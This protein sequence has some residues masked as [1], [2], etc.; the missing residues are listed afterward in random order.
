MSSPFLTLL[1]RFCFVLLCFRFL[2][3]GLDIFLVN[4][5]SFVLFLP[6]CTIL[7]CI[8][9]LSKDFVFYS[10]VTKRDI[11]LVYVDAFSFVFG[12]LFSLLL[13]IY[14]LKLST[15]SRSILL[16]VPSRRF[17]SIH[18]PKPHCTRL[19]NCSLSYEGP[20]AKPITPN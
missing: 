8:M 18:D 14:C 9:K 11:L 12:R 15:P 2:L 1:S 19:C 4:C 7:N 5:H 3:K 10:C 6:P 17:S 16:R 20:I 13:Q